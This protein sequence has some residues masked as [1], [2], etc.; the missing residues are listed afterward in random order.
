MPFENILTRS[1]LASQGSRWR[2][3]GRPALADL[4]ATANAIHGAVGAKPDIMPFNASNLGSKWIPIGSRTLRAG[5]R[6][7]TWI[8][9]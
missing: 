1:V 3:L 7:R 8:D 5:R 6:P 4:G 2:T 9:Y